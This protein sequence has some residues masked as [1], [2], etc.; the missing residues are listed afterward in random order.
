MFCSQ[1]DGM[2]FKERTDNNFRSKLAVKPF[3]CVINGREG[4]DF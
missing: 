2:I 1:K 4:F 3:V